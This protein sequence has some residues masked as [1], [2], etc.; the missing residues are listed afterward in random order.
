MKIN[1]YPGAGMWS[2][3]LQRITG[4]LL[5]TYLLIHLWGNH[6]RFII[7]TP[8]DPVFNFILSD[9][10][11]LILLVLILY[12]GFNGL[13]SVAIDLGGGL[14]LQRWVFWVLMA[15][16]AG[17]LYVVGMKAELF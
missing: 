7:R 5:V 6:F 4:L 17:L 14:R 11:L 16:G 12:H 1:A 15:L 2:W 8:L 13:R 3:L 10:F 9:N